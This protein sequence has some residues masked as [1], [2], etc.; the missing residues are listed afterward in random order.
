[1]GRG[2]QV[3]RRERS[4]SDNFSDISLRIRSL[5]ARDSGEPVSRQLHVSKTFRSRIDILCMQHRNLHR[6]RIVEYNQQ[7]SVHRRRRDPAKNERQTG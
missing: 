5:D 3:E 7:A 2:L 1:M 4:P 6:F